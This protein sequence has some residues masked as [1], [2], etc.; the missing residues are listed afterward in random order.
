MAIEITP[1]LLQKFQQEVTRRWP[2]FLQGR[3][4]FFDNINIRKEKEGRVVLACYSRCYYRENLTERE[5]K[6][7]IEVAKQE[8]AALTAAFPQIQKEIETAGMD[9]EFHYDYGQGA[10][11][12][13]E[14]RYGK[15]K[16]M[17]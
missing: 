3:P 12:V 15:F 17:I 10:I 14:E 7:R 2:D 13:A 8:I 1:D 6:E 16:S 4:L 11:L 5:A 9:F